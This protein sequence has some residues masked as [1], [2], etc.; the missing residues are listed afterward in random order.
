MMVAAPPQDSTTPKNAVV[1]PSPTAA[2]VQLEAP[3]RHAEFYFTDEMTVFQVEN[4]L[5][6]VHKHFL[7]E[8]S[9]IFNAMFSLPHGAKVGST[10][11]GAFDTNPIFLSDVTVLE[12]ETLLQ[13]FYKSFL[14]P[15]ESWI[16][17]LSIAHRYEFLD[18]QERAIHEIYSPFKGRQTLSVSSKEEQESRLLISVAEKYDIPPQNIVPLLIPFVVR[19]QTLTEDEVSSFSALTVSR[20]ARAREEFVRKRKTGYSVAEEIVCRIW[21]VPYVDPIK[22]DMLYRF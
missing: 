4:R 8:N 22:T 14:L 9:P 2:A 10:A 12:F 19:G 3:S 11:E 6:R 7:A 5:F 17:L 13:F 21:Q 16:A 1:Q 18:V 15:Q 20:L